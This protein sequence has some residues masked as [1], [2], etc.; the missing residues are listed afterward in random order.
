MKIKFII[1]LIVCSVF[2]SCSKEEDN[3]TQDNSVTTGSCGYYN[4]K[5][6]YKGPNGGCYYWNS[7]GNKTYVESK[8]CNC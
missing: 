5:P 1:A 2:I 4:D 3:Q 7:N 8:Y 6:T